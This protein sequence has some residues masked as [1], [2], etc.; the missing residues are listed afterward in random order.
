MDHVLLK[1]FTSPDEVRSFE[2][3]T[4]EVVRL[5][6]TRASWRFQPPVSEAFIRNSMVTRRLVIAAAVFCWI[7]LI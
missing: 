1:R 5:A 7:L 6:A 2:K 4:F 3:G